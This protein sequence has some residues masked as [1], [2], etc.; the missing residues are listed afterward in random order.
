[1]KEKH[2]KKEEIP[3]GVKEDQCEFQG[4]NCNVNYIWGAVMV[5]LL[6]FFAAFTW[7]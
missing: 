3:D 2:M 7:G 6:I 4:C 1:V 5:I